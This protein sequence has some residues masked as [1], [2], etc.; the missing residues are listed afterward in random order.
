[1]S[2]ERH[3]QQPQVNIWNSPVSFDSSHEQAYLCSGPSVER[4]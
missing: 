4:A 2:Q 3:E 1:M